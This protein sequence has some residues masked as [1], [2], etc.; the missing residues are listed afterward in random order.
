MLIP[1]DLYDYIYAWKDYR[2]EAKRLM[3]LLHLLGM[4][5][6]TLLEL[7]CGTGQYLAHM[8]GWTCTGV[9]LCDR[10]LQYAQRRNPKSKFVHANMKETGLEQQF[11]VIICLFGG[12]A[13]LHSDDLEQAI[14]HWYS[15]LNPGGILVIEPWLEEDQIHFGV[16]FVHTY[17]GEDISVSRSVVPNKKEDSCVLEFYFLLIHNKKIQKLH[18]TDIL[19]TY[20]TKWL[21]D[22]IGRSNFQMVLSERGFLKE[23]SLF[24]F[25]KEEKIPQ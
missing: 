13:Y 12:I 18:T 3:D 5:R 14:R 17:K 4:Q 7:A 21:L 24:C 1:A 15:L 6:G 11:D 25:K 22:K 20:Q 19:H 2:F 16:P 10:S 8:D 23:G 9:D